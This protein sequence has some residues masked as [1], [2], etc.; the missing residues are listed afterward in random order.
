MKWFQDK[1]KNSSFSVSQ[2][3]REVIKFYGV[4][5]E[6][7]LENRKRKA[8]DA[9]GRFSSEAPDVSIQ[10]DHYMAQAYAKKES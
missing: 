1:A 6:R 7:L 9:V 3:I 8:L 10:H 5:E 2:L 4:H